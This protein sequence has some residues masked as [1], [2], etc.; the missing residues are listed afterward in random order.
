MVVVVVEILVCIVSVCQDKH[1]TIIR[2]TNLQKITRKYNK[3]FA[4]IPISRFSIT[5]VTAAL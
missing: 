5:I 4:N 2:L 3:M 1:N